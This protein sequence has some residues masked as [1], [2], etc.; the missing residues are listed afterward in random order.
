MNVLYRIDG[1]EHRYH[2]RTVLAIGHLVIEA[3]RL[4][5]LVGAN[6]SGK[7]TLLRLLAGLERPTSGT[8]RFA[9]GELNRRCRRRI[10]WVMQQPYLLRGSAL[11]N[12]MLGLKF[13]RVPRRRQ[14]ALRALEQ[15]GFAADPDCPV[16]RLSGGERQRVAL[17]RCLALEP[18]VLL[19][20]EPFTHLDS[21]SCRHLETWLD[22]WVRQG[23]S[24]VFSDH[25]PNRSLALAGRVIALAAGRPV[26]APPVNVFTGRCLGRRFRTGKIE[27]VLPGPSRGT[28]IAVDPRDIVLSLTPW[29]S[30]MRN[31]FPGKVVGLRALGDCVRVTVMAGEKF[32]ALITRASCQEMGLTLGQPLWVQF[33]STAVR[34]F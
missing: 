9:G 19:L 3:N 33:K 11:D 32:E 30:S 16:E 26:D 5:A 8:I 24:V 2:G 23:G 17:A 15:V 22:R 6:G 7:S 13:H 12:V 28:H 34:V 1:L 4:T 21:A 31:R 20:D 10:G 25:D 14:R 27:I 29:P 18:E